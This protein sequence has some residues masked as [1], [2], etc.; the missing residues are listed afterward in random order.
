MILLNHMFFEEDLKLLREEFQ[1]VWGEK[2]I[3]KLKNSQH[4]SKDSNPEGLQ[5]PRCFNLTK[6]NHS[7]ILFLGVSY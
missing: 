3:L 4:P 7:A 6:Y 2:F 5:N 1:R